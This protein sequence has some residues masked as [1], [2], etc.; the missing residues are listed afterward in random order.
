MNDKKGHTS[1][2]KLQHDIDMILFGSCDTLLWQHRALS[3]GGLSSMKGDEIASALK[4]DPLRTVYEPYEYSSKG[5]SKA[6]YA[7]KKCE[8]LQSSCWSYIRIFAISILSRN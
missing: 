2:R 7:S 4:H 5:K 8:Y 6:N 1:S 3:E